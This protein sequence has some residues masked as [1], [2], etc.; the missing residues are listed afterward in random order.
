M[1]MTEDGY[2]ESGPTKDDY[3]ALWEK[4]QRREPDWDPDDPQYG[5]DA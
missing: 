5:I 1:P 3:L 4:R 2:V